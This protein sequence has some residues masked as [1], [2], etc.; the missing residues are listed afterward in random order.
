L[1]LA[2][3]VARQDGRVVVTATPVLMGSPQPS[4][5]AVAVPGATAQESAQESAQEDAGFARDTRGTITTLIKAYGSGELQYARAAGTA[6]TGLDHA[7]S[8]EEIIS[9]RVLDP[10]TTEGSESVRVGEVTLNWA[11]SGD[12]GTLRCT[13]RVELREDGGRWYLAAIGAPMGEVP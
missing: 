9:W 7:A 4:A 2:V 8:L 3:P 13:Y 10:E 5:E 6:F 11:L 12:A 1:N